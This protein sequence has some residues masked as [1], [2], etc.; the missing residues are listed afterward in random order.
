M[1]RKILFAAAALATSGVMQGA[2]AAEVGD[3][4]SVDRAQISCT[5]VTQPRRCSYCYNDDGT[6]GGPGGGMMTRSTIVVKAPFDVVPQL[7]GSM[8]FTTCQVIESALPASGP[9]NVEIIS[10]EVRKLGVGMKQTTI[11]AL[12]QN[13][14][15]TILVS[16]QAAH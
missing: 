4:V 1:K 8:G 16:G 15:R 3:I 2:Q 7:N 11:Q 5:Q 14:Q 9:V 10:K 12:I 13:N 6:F